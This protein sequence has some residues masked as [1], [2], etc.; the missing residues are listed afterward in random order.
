VAYFFGSPCMCRKLPKQNCGNH[1]DRQVCSTV[2]PQADTFR[3]ATDFE[4]F[5]VDFTVDGNVPRRSFPK[6]SC[7]P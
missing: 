7:C 5:K 4:M 6:W 1:S 2:V 3:K